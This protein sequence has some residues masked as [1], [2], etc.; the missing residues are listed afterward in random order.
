MWSSRHSLRAHLGLAVAA[1]AAASIVS[2]T[3]ALASTNV[4]G[5]A[6]ADSG[7]N[8]TDCH[9]LKGGHGFNPKTGALEAMCGT[10]HN[11]T[12][13]AATPFVTNHVVEGGLTTVDCGGCHDPH[14]PNTSKDPWGVSGE[15]RSLVR[16]DPRKFVDGAAKEAVFQ[17]TGDYAYATVPAGQSYTA[18][19]QTCHTATKYHTNTGVGTDHNPG[20]ACTLCHNHED[21]FQPT[22]A[23]DACHGS[24]GDPSPPKDLAGNTATT[25]R[26]V[27]AHRS[28]LQASG[29]HLEVACGDC[30][31]VPATVS[32]LG[33]MD[34]PQPAEL[35]FSARAGNTSWDGA[36]CSGSACH[37]A[38]LNAGG[39]N[40]APTWT[41]VDGSQAACGTC[42]GAP[43]PAPHPQST[44]CG[45]C[46]PNMAN[47]SPVFVSPQTHIDGN[48]DVDLSGVGCNACHGSAQNPAPPT[49]TQGNSSTALRSVGAHQSHLGVSDW[50]GPVACG[51]CH[52]VP[53][54]AG[55]PGHMDASPAEVTFGALAGGGTW[56]GTSCASTYC[57]GGT[58]NA[59]GSNTAPVWT[60]V[61][62][63]QAA[64][65]TCHGAPP[66]APHTTM[67][68]CGLCHPNVQPGTMTFSD[69]AS[70]INGTV[71]VD[72]SSA[73]CTS[74]HGG[75]GNAAPPVDTA[76]NTSTTVRGV[77]AHQSHLAT[78][79]WHAAVAC[80]SCHVV[81]TG[82]SDAGHIDASPAEL[83]FGGIAGG[84]SWDG[85]SCS[86]SYCH[87]GTLNAGGTNQAPVWTTVDGTQAACGTCH[88]AP[89][90]APHTTMT[91]CGL[92][93]PN[94]QPG[95]MTFSDPATHIDGTVDVDTSTAGCTSCHGGGGNP[96]PPVDTA[97]NTA[98]SAR[99]VGAHQSHLA[100]SGWHAAVTCDACH[101]VPVGIGD[102]GHID[103]G[104]AELTFGG[105]GAGTSWDG[106]SCSNSYCHGASLAAGGTNQAPV[107]TTV[108]GSQAACGTCHGAPPPAPHPAFNDCG[109]C[110]PNVQQG[111]LTF[112]DPTTHIDGN[113]D[114]AGGAG[115]C[116]ACHASAQ[117]SRR[118]I[119][120][121]SGDFVRSSH[122]VSGDPTDADCA[123]CHDQSTHMTGT[124]RLKDVDTGLEV[125][126]LTGDPATDAVEAAKLDAFCTACHDANGAG[127]AAPFSDGIMPPEVDATA[128][129]QSSHGG[130]GM[131]CA[132]DGE[133]F[134]CHANG[135][136][137]DKTHLLAPA[138]ATQTPIAGDPLRQEEGMCY[139]CHSTSGVALT[140]IQGAFSLASRHNVAAADQTGGA[141][142][143]CINCHNPHTATPTAMLAN[144][145]TGAPYV[146]VDYTM[147]CLT[148]H[149]GGAPPGVS[150]PATSPGTG[151][152]KSAYVGTT[153][154]LELGTG[155]GWGCLHCHN[156]HGSAQPTLLTGTYN[157]A[158][159]TQFSTAKYSVCFQCHKSQP[160]TLETEQFRR[161]NKH[162]GASIGCVWCHDAHNG[163]DPG[164]PGLVNFA[165]VQNHPTT[166]TFGLAGGATTLSQAYRV[167]STTNRSCYLVCHGKQH[168]PKGYD[169]TQ[170][171]Q[172]D[173][174]DPN[175]CATC[176][177]L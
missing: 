132:G 149:D 152:D 155:A 177:A 140:D 53:A 47:G 130:A 31:K 141:K 12:G 174:S 17:D 5:G 106:T 114:V 111:T 98:T 8:C 129:S 82:V 78:S 75:G 121:A 169:P 48:L 84:T 18:V 30:H 61:D 100:T 144:P 11:P 117:G 60:T 135:H 167:L 112:S 85:T 81:P 142:V 13:M 23:C 138:D 153:H 29:W 64:C 104:P 107:W 36:T 163:Y 145:D 44:N 19:C 46:H 76:G 97:G 14:G 49:D 3:P 151:Y 21:G 73:A 63:S 136:G 96:A 56:D 89:P 25:A 126:A 166:Y 156:A 122:H 158:A 137:S 168:T 170:N 72:T 116:T 6:H 79:D 38:D 109:L 80:D 10:C 176:H 66:P 113:V 102:A 173:T 34:S 99:G 22:G 43:P 159:T 103:P 62:G 108:N 28:H 69:P 139:S 91:N 74:C 4:W 26:G 115:G 154:D 83:T 39:T 119:V 105:I 77:G 165:F 161:H 118:V 123:V 175:A 33:H 32:A 164:E 1:A 42:H 101:V 171:P 88:G 58:L 146:P 124:V 162:F 65:G 134:G 40:T 24:S 50:H 27:G 133:S 70:H 20:V 2:A 172:V 86:S 160:L 35:T 92:C 16:S 7:V 95:T 15:N 128:W 67:T 147:F 148:C 157:M 37:G 127:G 87:G 57:H 41:V 150:F 131:S 45:L 68:D 94:V 93:H 9:A 54:N 71:D 55:A 51:E 52:V 125:A 120:G 110:H 143:E 59:G 90:P